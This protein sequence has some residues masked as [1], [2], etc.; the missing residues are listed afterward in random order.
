MKKKY[1]KP[2]MVKCVIDNADLICTSYGDDIIVIEEEGA[3]G[4]A[5]IYIHRR[6]G[7]IFED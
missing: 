6:T 5:P 7:W 3:D 2:T 4:S 1:M